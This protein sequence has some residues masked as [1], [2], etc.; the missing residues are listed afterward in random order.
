[1]RINMTCKTAEQSYVPFVNGAV[2][3]TLAGEDV[4]I[5]RYQTEFN[6]TAPDTIVMEWKGCYLWDGE[7]E[8][9]IPDDFLDG[10][11]LLRLEIEDDADLGYVC[12]PIKCAVEGR[13][14]NIA[15]QLSHDL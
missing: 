4:F 10:A 12:T 3:R 15:D 7:K 1:M 14:V 13:A 6:K 8:Q 9:K 11:T 5:D 2:F